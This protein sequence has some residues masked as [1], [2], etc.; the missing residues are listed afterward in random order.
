VNEDANNS[1]LYSKA[2]K[3]IMEEKEFYENVNLITH[4]KVPIIKFVESNTQI[5]FDLSFNTLDGVK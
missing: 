4:A 5:N 2:A 3:K 1:T